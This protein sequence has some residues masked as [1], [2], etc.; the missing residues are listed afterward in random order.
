MAVMDKP[1]GLGNSG[2][3]NVVCMTAIKNNKKT[4][5]FATQ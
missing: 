2:E 5:P 3:K 1:P 4:S